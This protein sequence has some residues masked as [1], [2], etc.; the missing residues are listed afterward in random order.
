MVAVSKA[1]ITGF[2]NSF[3]FFFSMNHTCFYKKISSTLFCKLCQLADC[4]EK[5]WNEVCL[6]AAGVPTVFQQQRMEKNHRLF[7]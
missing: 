3:I 1:N 4:I 5:E 6:S 7:Y 2:C